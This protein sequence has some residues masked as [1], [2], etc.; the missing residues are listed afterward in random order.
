MGELVEEG[1]FQATQH[2]DMF[3]PGHHMWVPVQLPKLTIGPPLFFKIFEWGLQ[4]N[5]IGTQLWWLVELEH[6][7]GGGG[8]WSVCASMVCLSFER[9]GLHFVHRCLLLQTSILTIVFNCFFFKHKLW[10]FFLITVTNIYKLYDPNQVWQGNEWELVWGGWIR[11]RE[12][13]NI[14]GASDR[15]PESL[16]KSHDIISLKGHFMRR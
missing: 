9:K 8:R 10:V 5:L 6:G 12:L 14:K 11:T 16:H 4:M 2:V 13:W 3:C 15:L 1:R 7:V